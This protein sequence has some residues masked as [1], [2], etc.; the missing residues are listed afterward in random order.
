MACRKLESTQ[1]GPFVYTLL[2]GSALEIVD[3]LEFEDYEVEDGEQVLLDLLLKRWPAKEQ[4]DNLGEHLEAVLG[5]QGRGGEPIAAWLGRAKEVFQKCGVKANVQFPTEAQ[6]WILLRRRGFTPDQ[7]AIVKA[8][9][10]KYTADDMEVAT[11]A[12]VSHLQGAEAATRR[13]RRD[14]G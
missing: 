2:Q 9:A 11:R 10:A 4:E 6:A 7:R 8:K 13:G 14:P 5:L 3:H 1:K 12:S